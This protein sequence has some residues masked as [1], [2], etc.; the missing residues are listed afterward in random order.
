[1]SEIVEA[2]VQALEGKMDELL[3]SQR[4]IEDILLGDALDQNR[5]GLLIRMDRIERTNSGWVRFLWMA[6]GVVLAA[7]VAV[8]AQGG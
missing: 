3:A 1:M 8:F 6:A 7:V 2:R 5:V 4:R